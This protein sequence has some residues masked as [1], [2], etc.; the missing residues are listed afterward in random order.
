VTVTPPLELD[1]VWFMDLAYGDKRMAIEW[2][3]TTAFGVSSL[4]DESYGERP[5]ET[6]RALDDVQRRITELLSGDERTTPPLGVLLS[7]LRELRGI[8]QQ[9]LGSK[10]GVRQATVS[11]MERRDD[12]QFS[13]L[14]RVVKALSGSLEIFVVFSDA[15]YRLFPDSIVHSVEAEPL[16]GRYEQTSV[17]S[18]VRTFSDDLNYETTFKALHES[19][20]LSWAR[21][22]GDDISSRGTVLE[23]AD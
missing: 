5:D 21:K 20:T 16:I 14:R 9:E 17:A 12:I 19:G 13:T 15:R 1:G 11:G 2:S 3:P 8:T 23:M 4:S 10:L 18:Y 6:F 22:A 7:R